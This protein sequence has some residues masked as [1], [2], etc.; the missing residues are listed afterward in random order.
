MSDECPLLETS[1]HKCAKMIAMLGTVV[2]GSVI[3]YKSGRWLENAY[4]AH[5]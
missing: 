2:Y 5:K 4:V 1:S 3:G